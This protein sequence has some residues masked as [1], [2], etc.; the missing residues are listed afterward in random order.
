M[1]SGFAGLGENL[2][3]GGLGVVLP[4]FVA[5]RVCGRGVGRR[6][7]RNWRFAF[8]GGG[9]FAAL[10]VFLFGFF[11]ILLNLLVFGNGLLILELEA[12]IFLSAFWPC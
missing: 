11:T 12:R 6:I 10:F 4:V 8:L 9:L 2:A 1:N 3:T 7:C 5:G